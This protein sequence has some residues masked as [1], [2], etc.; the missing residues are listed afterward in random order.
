M[1]MK[2]EPVITVHEDGVMVSWGAFSWWAEY[3][4]DKRCTVHEVADGFRRLASRIED[5]FLE[6]PTGHEE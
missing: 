5:T 1:D 6:S 4:A 2:H 3:N